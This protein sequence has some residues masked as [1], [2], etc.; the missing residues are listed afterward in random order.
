MIRLNR[1]SPLLLAAI[2]ALAA[3][4]PNNDAP[5]TDVGFD[6]GDVGPDVTDIGLDTADTADTADVAPDVPPEP[7]TREPSEPELIVVSV[8]PGLSVYRVGR[9]ATP[10][11]IVYD[12]YAEEMSGTEVNW[13]VVPEDAAELT[14]TGSWRFLREGAVTFRACIPLNEDGTLNICGSKKVVVDI[15]SPELE[16]YTPEGGAELVSSEHPTITITGRAWDTNGTLRV[17]VEGERVV[18]DADGNFSADVRPIYGINHFTVVASDGLNN[19][20]TKRAVDVMWAPHFHPMGIDPLT[21]NISAAYPEGLIMQLNQNYLDADEPIVI[22]PEDPILRTRDIAGLLEFVLSEVDVMSFI[23]TEPISDSESLQL[24]VPDATLGNPQVD[25]RVTDDGLEIFIGIPGLRVE[26]EGMFNLPGKG[27]VSLDGAVGLAASALIDLTVHKYSEAEDLVI[28]VNSIEVALEDAVGEFVD[29]DLNAV[30]EL[31]ETL[32]FFTLEDL[33]LQTLEDAFLADLPLLLADALGSIEGSILDESIELD[34][35]LGGPPINLNLAATLN[36][37]LPQARS[38]LNIDFGLDVGA[39]VAPAFP[40]SR[41]IAMSAPFD[42]PP[43]LF[44]TSR[45]QIAARVPLLNGILHTLWNSGLLNIDAT[46]VL[47]PA[48]S[49]LME[50]AQITGQLPPHITASRPGA[51]DYQFIL[52]VGQLEMEIWKGEQR[53]LLGI[54]LYVGVSLEIVDNTLNVVVQTEPQIQMWFIDPGED[55]IFD[56]VSTLSGLFADL[57]WPMLTEELEEGLS[58]DLPEIDLSAI[59]DFA[60]RLSDMTLALVLDHP[61]EIREGYFVLD[62]AF[63]GVADLTE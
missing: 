55:P 61:V 34:L 13:T 43:P 6:A 58:I 17:Y 57:L 14:D 52:T 40:S 3:C 53:D 23:G 2:F 4:N 7:D 12:Q 50:G 15:G 30:I 5:E 59:G 28:E 26:T 32:L 54:N 48:V 45:V 49:I 25:I 35:G 38:S 31:A 51:L 39:D 42:T 20:A 56:D 21:G 29:P 41:G 11:A 10:S 46:S 19:T 27:D 47:P 37:I 1:T 63:E 62:G 24:A 44:T 22:D 60:P 33:A 8:S 18:L 9:R 36:T 16:I